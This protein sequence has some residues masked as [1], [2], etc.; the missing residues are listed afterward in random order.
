MA[1][2]FPAPARLAATVALFTAASAAVAASPSSSYV[3]ITRFAATASGGTLS[4]TDP[5][6]SFATTAAE[7]GGLFGL[8]SD[9]LESGSFG[10]AAVGAS[11]V[12]ASAAAS[13]TASQTFWLTADSKP[14]VGAATNQPNKA[15]SLGGQSASFTL[16]GAGTVVFT[17]DYTLAAGSPGGNA[18][19][20]YGATTLAFSAFDS[21]NS[22]GALRS[23]ALN[24]FAAGVTRNGSFTVSVA[25]GA[26]EVG[27]YDLHGAAFAYSSAAA[28]PEPS[29]WA[30]MGA[31]L[32]GVALLRRRPPSA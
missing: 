23:D 5:Y 11:T 10:F 31:G 16:G 2:S 29:S 26:G 21:D 17:I 19:T 32:L 28:V 8:R 27:Y 13:T 22:N 14:S 30:L 24:S 9:S 1:R 25:L 20:D 6:Q 4:W 3:L 12:N 15:E 18:V 7:A